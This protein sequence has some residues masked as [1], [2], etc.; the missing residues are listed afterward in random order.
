M[1]EGLLE[2]EVLSRDSRGLSV[3][4]ITAMYSTDAEN[5]ELLRR[6]SDLPALPKAWRDYF[7]ERLWGPDD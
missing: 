3:S 6:A 4:E 2:D 7:R 5:Q 1:T